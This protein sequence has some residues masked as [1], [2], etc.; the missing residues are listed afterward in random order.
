MSG[1]CN[2]LYSTVDCTQLCRSSA[3]Y[4]LLEV[5]FH[6]FCYLWSA[7]LE[8]LIFVLTHE[9]E[10]LVLHSFQDSRLN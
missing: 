9:R 2:F 3:P 8:R 1:Y 7:S 5:S 10:K 4:L 6:G